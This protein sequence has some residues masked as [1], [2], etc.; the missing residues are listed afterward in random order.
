MLKL[1]KVKFCPVFGIYNSYYKNFA[2]IKGGFQIRVFLYFG[3][4]LFLQEVKMFVLDTC[5]SK[6]SFFAKYIMSYFLPHDFDIEQSKL[7][8]LSPM[9]KFRAYYGLRDAQPKLERWINEYP[10][11]NLQTADK[12][13][14]WSK[15]S[16]IKL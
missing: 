4:L 13:I 7:Y 9:R 16:I 12:T 1:A 14:D 10:F 3:K 5:S 11:T 15:A 8:G 6:L 2:F